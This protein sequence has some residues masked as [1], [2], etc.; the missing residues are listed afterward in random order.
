MRSFLVTLYKITIKINYS[1]SHYLNTCSSFGQTGPTGT[2]HQAV[3]KNGL[4]VRKGR[5]DSP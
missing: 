5:Y 2:D 1:L 4:P 3:V